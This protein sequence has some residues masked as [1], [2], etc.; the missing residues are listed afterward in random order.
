MD[1]FGEGFSSLAQLLRLPFESLKISRT[2]V[3]NLG[4]DARHMQYIAAIVDMMHALNME[5]VAEGV[6]T[7]L[8]WQS[9]GR[10]GFDLVQGYYIARPLAADAALEWA[11][12]NKIQQSV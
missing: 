12:E 8:E 6:E 4:D 9:V 3:Q 11:Q 5:V 10:C 1:D 7:E 2:L